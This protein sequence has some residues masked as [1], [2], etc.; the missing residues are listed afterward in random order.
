MLTS[1]FAGVCYG[2]NHDS[3]APDLVSVQEAEVR[4]ETRK[5]K[6]LCAPSMSAFGHMWTVQWAHQREEDN[7]GHI[8]KPLRDRD[9]QISFTR[10]TE[11]S[12]MGGT[13]RTV[14]G[15]TRR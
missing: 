5:S 12:A 8:F 6:A 2:E 4:A 1:E 3:I 11:R 9:V 13:K 14:K 10:L 15:R 7:G